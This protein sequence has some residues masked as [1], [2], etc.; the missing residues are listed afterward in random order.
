MTI[1]MNHQL[2]IAVFMRSHTSTKEHTPVVCHLIRSY[3]ILTAI[4]SRYL[5]FIF[6]RSK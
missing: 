3:A 6:R 5:C 2:K 1:E 4:M